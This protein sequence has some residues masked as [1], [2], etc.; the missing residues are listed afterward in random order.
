MNDCQHMNFDAR[1]NV[2]RLT[3]QNGNVDR[4]AADVRVQCAECHTPFEF[5][6]LPIGSH[7]DGATMSA[8]AQEARLAIIPFGSKPAPFDLCGSDLRKRN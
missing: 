7:F 4:Y 8:D 3:D 2:T 6:G 5:R 1:V